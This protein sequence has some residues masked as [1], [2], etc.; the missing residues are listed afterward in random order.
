MDDIDRKLIALLR[1]DGRRSVSDLAA[2]LGLARATVR[3]RLDRLIGS[4]EIAGFTVVMRSD[5][6][7]DPVRAITLVEIE[8]KASDDVARRLAAMPEVLSV[9][10]T[11]GRWDLVAE[12][13]APDLQSFDETLR[14]IRLLPGI[15]LT[16]TNILLSTRKRAGMVAPPR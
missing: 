2:E 5:L 7:A 13:G 4:G 8:G 3:A 1:H 16:E 15:S 10:T 12:I 9:H 11:N 14:R 6:Q